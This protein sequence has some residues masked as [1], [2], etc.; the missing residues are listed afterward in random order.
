MADKL[1]HWSSQ[2]STPHASPGHTGPNLHRSSTSG[3]RRGSQRVS[4]SDRRPI[5]QSHYPRG[6]QPPR[7]HRRQSPRRGG[8]RPDPVPQPGALDEKSVELGPLVI[9]KAVQCAV[10][11][12]LP[13]HHDISEQLTPAAVVCTGPIRSPGSASPPRSNPR[14]ATR[15]TS[16]AFNSGVKARAVRSPER[17]S[18]AP[19][20]RA[21]TTILRSLSS[22]S[23]CLL[24]CQVASP[25]MRSPPILASFH[26]E[27]DHHIVGASKRTRSKNRRSPT[28]AEPQAVGGGY[29]N[30]GRAETSYRAQRADLTDMPL[31]AAVDG[32]PRT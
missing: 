22:R 14:A 5:R 19:Q 31:G 18:S 32:R 23:I 16:R 24:P 28:Y 20:T 2:R 4:A 21:A 9:I 10:E 7:L 15:S 6:V 3:S 13:R 25:T 26:S 8:R 17:S 27:P 1:R 29:R 30:L 12:L 11:P